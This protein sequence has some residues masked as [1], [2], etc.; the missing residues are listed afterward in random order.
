MSTI[1]SKQ[2]IENAKAEVAAYVAQADELY[3]KL[4]QTIQTLSSSGFIGAAAD[5]Y[6]EFFTSKATPAL[7]QNLTAPD[8][9]LMAGIKT[10]LENIESQLIDT[11][12]AQLGEQNKDPGAGADAAQ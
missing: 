12:D 2:T 8:G 9:S 7:T 1:L 11:V 4:Q 5:G 10:L 6:N 3:S